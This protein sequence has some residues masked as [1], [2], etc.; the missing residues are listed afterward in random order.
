MKKSF[1]GYNKKSVEETIAELQEE[2]RISEEKANNFQQKYAEAQNIISEQKASLLNAKND[3]NSY[4]SKYYESTKRI[5]SREKSLAN[6]GQIYINAYDSASAIVKTAQEHTEAF[7][8][9]ISAE[10]AYTGKQTNTALNDMER[11][12]LELQGFISGVN[13]KISDLKRQVNSLFSK[14]KAIPE[15]YSRIGKIKEDLDGQIGQHMHTFLHKSK[16]FLSDETG[17]EVHS[18]SIKAPEETP[19][20][21]SNQLFTGFD[22][23]PNTLKEKTIVSVNLLEPVNEKTEPI[24][25]ISENPQNEVF[26]S[27][28]VNKVFP[29]EPIYKEIAQSSEINAA[30]LPSKESLAVETEKVIE[31]EP[32]AVEE[33]Y[34]DVTDKTSVSQSILPK[35]SEESDELS[36]GQKK[37]ERVRDILSK[38]SHLS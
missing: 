35:V 33:D 32:M 20:H 5:G 14:A 18:E 6:V 1:F 11:L 29:S 15:A 36:L 22:A 34:I 37:A 24:E 27:E 38:Y 10:A 26:Q 7:M 8:R 30:L 4:M 9:D 19:N 28:P 2:L 17:E 13:L 23:V 16:A 31:D 12:E 21:Y 25:K 3:L